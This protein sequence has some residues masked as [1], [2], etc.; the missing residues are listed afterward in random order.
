MY[1]PLDD[2]QLSDGPL[3]VRQGTVASVIDVP[4]D[5]PLHGL[6][7]EVFHLKVQLQDL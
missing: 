5:P 4:H 3:Q 2:R 6:A 7:G 1:I